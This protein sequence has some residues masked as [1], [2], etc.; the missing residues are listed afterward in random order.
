[1]DR[2]EL[3]L[4][5]I[6]TR[7]DNGEFSM[8]CMFQITTPKFMDEDGI[9]NDKNIKILTD[10]FD[11]YGIEWQNVDT[12]GG[13]FNLNREWIETSNI[14]CYVEYCGVYPVEWDIEDVVTLEQLDCEGKVIIRV[15]WRPEEDVYIP[16]H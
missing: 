7:R 12:I 4:E 5:W 6:K 11:K 2:K 8:P 10:I 1:M 15:L 16:N 14:P 9:E 3:I 13:A